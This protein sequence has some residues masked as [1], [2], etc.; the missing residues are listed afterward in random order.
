M[1]R[2]SQGILFHL[3]GLCFIF[4][5]SLESTIDMAHLCQVMLIFIL[6]VIWFLHS[7]IAAIFP[8]QQSNVRKVQREQPQNG[9]EKPLKGL[10]GNK[11]FLK[12]AGFF[13]LSCLICL[14]LP[15]IW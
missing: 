12:M 6:E 15:S 9:V 10:N 11:V 3:S 4:G 1:N 14:P 13:P 5:C 7:K 2:R 8:E